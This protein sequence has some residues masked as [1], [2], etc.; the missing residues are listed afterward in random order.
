MV[1]VAWEVYVEYVD[2]YC[3]EL[4]SYIMV[5]VLSDIMV[6]VGLHEPSLLQ[7]LELLVEP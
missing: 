5:E 7:S 4:L 6:E 2:V 1:E 3:A